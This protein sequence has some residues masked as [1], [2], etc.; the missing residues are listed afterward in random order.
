MKHKG[1]TL[2][3]IDIVRKRVAQG[4][5]RELVSLR[6]FI[7][8]TDGNQEAVERL[9]GDSGAKVLAIVT[10]CIMSQLGAPTAEAGNKPNS[11]AARAAKRVSARAGVGAKILAGEA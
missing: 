8:A 1:V 11:A 10:D 4:V 7:S 3:Q 2:K 6:A 9:R 5:V